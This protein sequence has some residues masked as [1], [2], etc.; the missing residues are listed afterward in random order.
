[1]V[2]WNTSFIK[3]SNLVLKFSCDRESG[4]AFSKLPQWLIHF[5]VQNSPLIST[6]DLRSSVILRVQTDI[7]LVPS[8]KFLWWHKLEANRCPSPLLRSSVQKCCYNQRWSQFLM[9]YKGGHL[10]AY[11]TPQEFPC[12][13]FLWHLENAC[14]CIQGCCPE[15]LAAAG[16]QSCKTVTLGNFYKW[17]L[18]VSAVPSK[19]H[20]TI[21]Y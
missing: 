8:S 13:G 12:K 5:T 4:T 17:Q 9:P 3:T 20:I 1:M 16:A 19:V 15:V 7:S 21:A 11:C 2:K 18:S 14:K 10:V 6:L